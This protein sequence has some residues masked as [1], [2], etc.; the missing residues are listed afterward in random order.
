MITDVVCAK[1]TWFDLCPWGIIVD[2]KW[3][4]HYI[5]SWNQYERFF[6]NLECV[7]FSL[8]DSAPCAKVQIADSRSFYNHYLFYLTFRKSL[9]PFY[10]L[11]VIRRVI[12]K[13]FNTHRIPIADAKRDAKNSRSFADIMQG[14]ENC[15]LHMNVWK[16]LDQLKFV[17][18]L[19]ALQCDMKLIVKSYMTYK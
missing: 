16:K 11:T 19:H 15:H 8:V 10:K 17:L 1:K 3:N 5:K 18:F 12:H 7:M 4:L 13:S 6:N 2:H 14:S 9:I